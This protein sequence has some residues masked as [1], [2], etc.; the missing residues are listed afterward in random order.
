MDHHIFVFLSVN[1]TTQHNTTSIPTTQPPIKTTKL[2]TKTYLATMRLINKKYTQKLNSKNS[3][4]YQ[5]LKKRVE[6]AVSLTS[7]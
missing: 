2:K 6:D 7:H 5:Q 1:T 3:L 4:E